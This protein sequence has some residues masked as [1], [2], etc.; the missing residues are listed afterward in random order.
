MDAPEWVVEG[1]RQLRIAVAWERCVRHALDK[2]LSRTIQDRVLEGF[3]EITWF[4]KAR[5]FVSEIANRDDLDKDSFFRDAQRHFLQSTARG[6]NASEVF[7]MLQQSLNAAIR[8]DAV[9]KRKTRGHFVDVPDWMSGSG[10]D[11]WHLAASS[12]MNWADISRASSEGVKGIPD[13]ECTVAAARDAAPM[14][15]NLSLARALMAVRAEL[16][17]ISPNWPPFVLQHASRKLELK[18]R[19]SEIASLQEHERVGGQ[20]DRI[21]LIVSI[22]D[23]V[24]AIGGF[25]GDS[26]WEAVLAAGQMLFRKYDLDVQLGRLPK[27]PE[28][29]HTV[30]GSISSPRVTRTGVTILSRSDNSVVWNRPTEII[31]PPPLLSALNLAAAESE[32]RDFLDLCRS[33]AAIVPRG[34]SWNSMP[35]DH[36][37]IVWRLVQRAV[38]QPTRATSALLQELALAGVTVEPALSQVEICGPRFVVANGEGPTT[39]GCGCAVRFPDGSVIG[40]AVWYVVSPARKPLARCLAECEPLITGL[41][42]QDSDWSGWKRYNEPVWRWAYEDGG[43]TDITTI[44]ALFEEI[45]NRAPKTPHLEMQY[46]NLAARL[47]RLA[48]ERMGATI[49]P[50]LDPDSLTVRPLT[51][52]PTDE[53]EIYWMKDGAFTGE[54]LRVHRF[55]VKGRPAQLRV[56]LGPLTDKLGPWLQLPPAPQG[57]LR[58]WQE[59]V[60]ELVWHPD[61]IERETAVHM[62]AVREW[63]SQSKEGAEWLAKAAPKSLWVVELVAQKWCC[64]F[65]RFDSL[66]ESISWPAD[67]DYGLGVEWEFSGKTSIDGHIRGVRYAISSERAEG[68]FSLGS[69]SKASPALSAA[70]D[71][72]AAAR[73]AVVVRAIWSREVAISRKRNAPSVE[74][75]AVELVNS[76]AGQGPEAVEAA[77]RWL[78]TAGLTLLPAQGV[79]AGSVGFAFDASRS[80]NE[81]WVVT[82]GISGSVH[83]DRVAVVRIAAGPAPKGYDVLEAAVAAAARSELTHRLADWPEAASNGDLRFA[84]AEFHGLA[85]RL[86][87]EAPLDKSLAAV[88][89]AIE[90]LLKNEFGISTWIPNLLREVPAGYAQIRGP[91]R[92]GRVN[93]AACPILLDSAGGLIAPGDIHVE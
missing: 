29:R 47:Y 52:K 27:Q 16:E 69:K 38:I 75:F 2:K 51:C 77:R 3:L 93:N 62:K 43:S 34:N 68:V 83:A 70:A 1:F 10:A 81:T 90:V 85:W 57:P 9:T 50:A 56:R 4:P 14:S 15:S 55:G 32:D 76:L 48:T 80:K 59:A 66:T 60:K 82:Y 21:R 5:K 72:M 74:L 31:N 42:R 23:T 19:L 45:Y 78:A 36:R 41:R 22:V 20:L 46:K 58:L 39:S 18:L 26:G 17:S 8:N 79:E 53:T 91:E 44:V 30:F 61:K 67:A 24:D 87:G 65:P 89:D 33:A 54:V 88:T 37:D 6:M 84:A 64:L 12:L 63:L 11:A 25:A 7:Q 73:E 49:I 28:G 92:T 13:L 71:L 40:P 86:R 35:T